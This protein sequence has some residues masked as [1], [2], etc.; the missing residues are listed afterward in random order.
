MCL[1]VGQGAILPGRPYPDSWEPQNK[2]KVLLLVHCCVLEI[3]CIQGY[4]VPCIMQFQPWMSIILTC[5]QL[6]LLSISN[7]QGAV[8]CLPRFWAP[9]ERAVDYGSITYVACSLQS[10]LQLDSPFQWPLL[11]MCSSSKSNTRAQQSGTYCLSLSRAYH[12]QQAISR[13]FC[14]S[15][16]LMFACLASCHR[17][18]VFP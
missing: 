15:Y 13:S 9:S 1:L 16:A 7:V 11:S 4:N 8:L 18:V 3:F 12:A 14:G 5:T 2:K 17:S 6:V 10:S